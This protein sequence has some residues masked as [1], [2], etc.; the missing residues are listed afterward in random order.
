MAPQQYYRRWDVYFHGERIGE[1]LAATH[2]AACLRAIHKFRIS[3]EDRRKLQV[4]P[5]TQTAAPE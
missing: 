3:P 1:V 2:D 5:Q 4:R